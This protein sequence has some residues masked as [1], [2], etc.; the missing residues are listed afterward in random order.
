[1]IYIIVAY[2]DLYQWFSPSKTAEFW[3][4]PAE[5]PA[6]KRCLASLEC[7]ARNTFRRVPPADC[8]RI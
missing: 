7:R 4:F 1:L 8:R 6:I 2:A 5:F 3:N